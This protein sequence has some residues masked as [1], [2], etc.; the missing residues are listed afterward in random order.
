M[1]DTARLVRV[2]APRLGHIPSFDGFRGIFVLQVVLYH[3]GVTAK[4]LPGSPI[5]IDWF[6]VASGFLITSLLLDEQNR[7]NTIDMRQPAML[8][9]VLD[10][11]AVSALFDAVRRPDDRWRVNRADELFSLLCFDAWWRRYAA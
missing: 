9:L 4:L 11:G 10:A 5:I 1:T 7:S 2:D 3:A 8:R 6:F